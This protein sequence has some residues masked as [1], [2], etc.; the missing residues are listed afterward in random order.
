MMRM[1]RPLPAFQRG[2]RGVGGE[3]TGKLC[4][5][6]LIHLQVKN[7]ESFALEESVDQKT[8]HKSSLIDKTS[9]EEEGVGEC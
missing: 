1:E 4:A 7:R 5:Y 6:K 8:L 9:P 3:I 2:V